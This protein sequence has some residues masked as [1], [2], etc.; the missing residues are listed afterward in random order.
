[1][2]LVTHLQTLPSLSRSNIVSILCNI[3]SM[4]WSDFPIY[5]ICNICA[6]I[7]VFAQRI[8]QLYCT[9]YCTSYC[10]HLN[11]AHLCAILMNFQLLL[12][13]LHNI[14]LIEFVAHI[15]YIRQLLH[16]M[17]QCRH[18]IVHNKVDHHCC[19]LLVSPPGRLWQLPASM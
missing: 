19:C 4:Y 13:I 5:A 10:T 6:H 17:A 15:A 8:S 18:T 16:T 7:Q 2:L 11:C 9:S 12:C 3:C 1:M 14:D